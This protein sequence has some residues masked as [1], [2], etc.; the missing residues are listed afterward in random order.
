MEKLM[1][2]NSINTEFTYCGDSNIWNELCTANEKTLLFWDIRQKLAFNCILAH[3]M[4]IT[5]C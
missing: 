4:C 2:S 3:S 5:S 1:I